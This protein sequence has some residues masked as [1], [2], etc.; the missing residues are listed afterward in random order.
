LTEL[1]QSVTPR[2]MGRPPLKRD[3]KV[4]KTTLWLYRPV[5]DRIIEL[6]GKQGLSEFMR[7]A[8]EAELKRRERKAKDQIDG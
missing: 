3:M 4:E 2:R 1:S 5:V 8:A 6:V 7:T